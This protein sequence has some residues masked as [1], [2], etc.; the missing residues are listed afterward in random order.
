M[1]HFTAPVGH[2]NYAVLLVI[3]VIIWDHGELFVEPLLLPCWI[4][5]TH[6]MHIEWS[7]PT[8]WSPIKVLTVTAVA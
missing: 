2:S 3:V 4:L 7:P 1:F 6:G 5:A 8:G